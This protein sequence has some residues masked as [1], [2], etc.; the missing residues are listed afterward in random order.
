MHISTNSF[1]TYIKLIERTK[2]QRIHFQTYISILLF[3]VSEYFFHCVVKDF[4]F[5]V[6]LPTPSNWNEKNENLASTK[7][8]SK[9]NPNRY[10]FFLNT[11]KQIRRRKQ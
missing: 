7:T 6:L 8:L 9:L 2:S 3:S 4:S 5:I 11:R 10:F 1:I